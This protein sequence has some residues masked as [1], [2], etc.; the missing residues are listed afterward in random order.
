MTIF[1]NPRFKSKYVKF[2]PNSLYDVEEIQELTSKIN[3]TFVRL[4][5]YYLKVSEVKENL[6]NIGTS[7]T[8]EYQ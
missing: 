5:T 6:H 1:L 4:S 7:T 3:D 2:Y 8:S